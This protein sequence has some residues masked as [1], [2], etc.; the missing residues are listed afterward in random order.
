MGLTNF[1]NGISS[2]GMPL[3]SGSIP[4]TTGKFWFVDSVTGSNGN[5]GDRSDEPLATIVKAITL[6]TAAKGDTILCLP[7]HTEAVIAA[8][9]IALSKSSVRLIGLG[10]GRARPVITYTTAAAASV[11]ISGANVLVENMVFS[12]IGVD[13][14][15]AMINITA[16]DVT[17]RNCEIEHA[18]ATN[19]AILGVLT[20]AAANRLRIEDCAFHG[21]P[22]AGT[23][24]AI[25]IVGGDDHVI[26]RN[27]CIGD[28]I[29][30]LGVIDNVT[31]ACRNVFIEGNK[32]FNRTASSAVAMTFVATSDGMIS[33]NYM[34][35][36][37]GTAPIVGANMSWVG[38]NYYAATD[39][40]AGTL[41]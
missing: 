28:Y 30:T 34:Q 33:R 7:G 27:T 14:L 15:T 13:A 39:A 36:L 23:V 2:F 35:V 16:A 17:L 3:P 38:G 24:A 21:T 8:G 22:H 9:T 5:R 6:C 19:Q 26:S 29:T 37:T 18:D 25:R 31:T 1:P 32:I 4:A 11:D 12:G 10:T 40:T 41:I 20:T